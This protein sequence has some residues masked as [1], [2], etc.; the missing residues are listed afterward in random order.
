VWLASGILVATGLVVAL[1]I[2]ERE[3][4]P[5]W[6]LLVFTGMAASLGF[7]GALVVTRQ[8]RNAVGWILWLSSIGVAVSTMAGAYANVVVTSTG[9]V[10]DTGALVALMSQVGVT[11]A[12]AG[13]IIL[14]PLLFP[15]GR[16][17]GPRWRWLAAYAVVVIVLMVVRNLFAP[18]PLDDYPTIANPLGVPA[19]AAAAP[20]FELMKGPGVLIAALLAIGSAF[21]RYRRAGAVERTQL[22]WFG[23]AIALTISLFALSIVGSEE[24]LDL[25]ALSDFGWLAG[26][27]SLSLIPIA[28]GMAIL[29]YRLYE[30]DRIVSRTI[31]WA[32]VT[33]L[34]LAMFAALVVVLQAILA[35]LTQESTLA[36]AASTLVA[37]ALFQPLRRRVQRVVDRRFD[38]A[39]YDG[40]RTVD[41]F[42][43]HLRNEVD[44]ATIRASLAATAGDSVRP[45]TSGVWLRSG[46]GR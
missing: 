1:V 29:R 26:I 4:L 24:A 25:P 35:P 2:P 38:R 22:R 13:T 43:E 8:P 5:T 34:L 31:G 41:A 20:L 7:V 18:G 44:L 30:I 21:V 36:V 10:T 19:L 6:A 40:Q 17:L 14:I 42:A 12:I 9:R 11:P 16:L 45:A 3:A 37:F 15:D 27:I 33:G 39:R 23:A 32:L 46:T 28:I